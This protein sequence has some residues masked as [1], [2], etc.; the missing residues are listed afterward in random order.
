[1]EEGEPWTGTLLLVPRPGAIHFPS[2]AAS[3]AST[4]ERT[5]KNKGGWRPGTSA[6]LQAVLGGP[7]ELSH[8]LEPVLGHPRWG[9]WDSASPLGYRWLS[10]G[11]PCDPPHIT[12][13]C[14]KPK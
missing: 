6:L 8:H 2:L 11:T 4:W 5:W 13:L 12:H 10:L 14:R 7:G 1:M 9:W 3:S